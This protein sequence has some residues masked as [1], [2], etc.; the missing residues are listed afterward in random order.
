MEMY[1]EDDIFI[2]GDSYRSKYQFAI[3]LKF[4]DKHTGE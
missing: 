1:D 4:K 3:D 2:D